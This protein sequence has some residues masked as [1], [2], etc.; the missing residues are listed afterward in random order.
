MQRPVIIVNPLSSGSE[1]ATT[2]KARNVPAVAVVAKHRDRIGFAMEVRASDFIDVVPIQDNLVEVLRQHNPLAV[3]PGTESAVPLAEKLTE[4]LTPEMA[5]D[6]AKSLSRVHKAHMQRALVDSGVPAIETVNASSQ[7]EV[8]RWLEEKNLLNAP[9][10]LK[11]PISAGSDKVFHIP[12]GGDWRKAFHLITSGLSRLTQER[13]ETAV[14]Q[15]E[16]IGTEYA[17]GTVSAHGK[18]YLSHL[19]QYNKTTADDRK[20]VFDHVE[21]M[22]FDEDVHGE[23]WEYTKRVLDALGIRWGAAHNEVMLTQNGPRL[24]E[25]GARMLGGP[26][27]GF[28]REATGCSQADRLAEL[29]IDGDVQSK[30]YTFKKTVVPVFLHSP[31]EGIVSNVEALNDLT[32]LPSL[33]E[34]HVWFENGSKVPKTVDYLT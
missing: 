8:E 15:E 6:P 30:E 18:H 12:E 22:D 17:V 29:Y 9:L 1:L 21:F 23:L 10:I 2:F 3:I 14:V 5:N 33:F 20:T 26:T 19:I 25:T 28:S 4:A 31:L 7:A 16:A 11:P 27:V 13:N 24:I 32:K 34:K